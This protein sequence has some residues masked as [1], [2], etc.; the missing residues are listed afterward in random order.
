MRAKV[1][2]A[3]LLSLL[4]LALSWVVVHWSIKEMQHALNDLSKPS[5]KLQVT[6]D[7]FKRVARIDQRQKTQALE[8]PSLPVESFLEGTDDLRLRLDSLHH[9]SSENNLQTV[10]VDSMYSILDARDKLFIDY[11]KLRVDLVNNRSLSKY[12]RNLSRVIS[13]KTGKIDSSIVTTQMRIT[14]TTLIPVD[15]MEE[16]ERSFF[17]R[18]FKPKKESIQREVKTVVEEDLD[19]TI[20]TV[21]RY[22]QDSVIIQAEEIL[23]QLKK[24]QQTR[25]H[26]LVNQE[27]ELLNTG[28]ALIGQLLRVLHDF[29]AEELRQTA[30]MEARVNSA[31]QEKLEGYSILVFIFFFVAAT[32]VFLMLSDISKSNQ[33]RLRLLKAKEEAEQLG[34]I[35]QRFLANMSHEIRTPLQSII[36]FA[37]QLTLQENNRGEKAIMAIH[38]SSRHLLHIV[39]EVL[40][41]SRIT[42]GKFVLDNQPFNMVQ[43]LTEV[44]ETIQL[45]C[46]QKGLVFNVENPLENLSGSYYTGDP[47]R[48]KQI[49]YNL[50][51]NAVKFTSEGSISFVVERI[52]SD[53]GD[54]FI[55][56]FRDTGVG[57]PKHE[58][59]R[60][61]QQFEQVETG[62]S[63][64]GTG[65]GLTI[66]QA[67][68]DAKGGQLSLES[69]PGRGTAFTVKLHYKYS[70]AP[71]TVTKTEKLKPGV[72]PG[73]QV[74]LIDDD[75]LIGELCHQIVSRNGIPLQRFLSAEEFLESYWEEIFGAI[76]LI[77]IRLPGISGIEL[78]GR[79]RQVL[80]TKVR[81]IAVT[82]QVMSQDREVILNGDFDDL[83]IKPYTEE[84]LLSVLQ[85]NHSFGSDSVE[86]FIPSTDIPDFTN[87]KKMVGG[88]MDLIRSLILEFVGDSGK[89]L[90]ALFITSNEGDFHAAS[91]HAHRLAGRSGQMGA[92]RLAAFLRELEIDL[93]S[94]RLKQP[95]LR[96]RLKELSHRSG[97]LF[98]YLSDQLELMQAPQP[99]S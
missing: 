68:V 73:T 18:L 52:P 67:L 97:N 53:S 88:D 45:Q 17:A 98:A 74:I 94:D 13:R 91:D 24:D 14:T 72:D 90:E 60:I 81:L 55:F 57:I 30:Q 43:V 32:L 35:K 58:Q 12:I 21:A 40:D 16:K 10:R 50:L 1:L 65:L 38:H 89:D 84:E 33:Y 42:S 86:T 31:L 92:L 75:A 23:R 47:F 66:A 78:S 22:Q 95:Q 25:S 8:N 3:F 28:D 54:D 69:K 99:G 20:D 59:E 49:M 39:N 4:A 26:R 85:E 93:R 6:D 37:E 41:Y 9:L 5:L 61:F 83:L 64:N 71:K 48:L 56:H 11:L 51:G 70:E 77:D 76:I 2:L 46:D 82:A 44:R 79:I 63:A 62:T 36:G 7:I 87:L 27:L 19:I 80:G 15:T 29:E 34:Q 96:E